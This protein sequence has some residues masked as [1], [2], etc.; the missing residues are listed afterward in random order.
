MQINKKHQRK[1]QKPKQQ[2][3]KKIVNKKEEGI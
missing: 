1:F 3:E 2:K